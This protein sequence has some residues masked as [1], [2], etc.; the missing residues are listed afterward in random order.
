MKILDVGCGKNKFKNQNDI[1]IGLDKHRF[2]GVDVLHDLERFPYP[3]K[4]EEFDAIFCSHILEH[5]KEPFYVIKECRRI[6]KNGG[7]IFIRTPH[8]SSSWAYALVHEKY[9]SAAAFNMVSCLGFRIDKLRVNWLMESD[10]YKKMQHLFI[11]NLTKII[12]YLANK[13]LHFCERFWCY[14]VGGFSEI[15]V[16][17]T[18]I[19][20]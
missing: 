4:D 11:K 9:F 8:F 16:E 18:K 7:K 10:S 14:W 1:I 15:E 12:N 19:N 5:L 3:F 2:E 20:K 17:L 6:L 13:N